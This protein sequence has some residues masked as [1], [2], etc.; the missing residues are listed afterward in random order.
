M[1][2]SIADD[3]CMRLDEL[4]NQILFQFDQQE[5][6]S[7]GDAWQSGYDYRMW[8]ENKIIPRD[9]LEEDEIIYD[10]ARN[11]QPECLCDDCWADLT[12]DKYDHRMD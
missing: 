1:I 10:S 12:A 2:Q 9:D 8:D 11:K 3:M 7:I 5:E 6:Q 4:E